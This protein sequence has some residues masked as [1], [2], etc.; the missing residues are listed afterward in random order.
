MTKTV[1]ENVAFALEVCG[2]PQDFINKRTT[3]VLKITGLED[4][5][6]YFPN[7]LS[8]GE[9]QRTAI[10]R[11]LVHTPDLIIA[12]EP[13]GNLDQENAIALA[14]L[15]VKINKSGTTVILS[16]HNQE[17]V[18]A[19]KTRVITIENGRIVSDKK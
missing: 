12:D 3:E 2:Y 17:I 11:A 13:T 10:A 19:L 16:T 4:K 7:Q 1:F 6:N 15:L 14:N 18:D 5:R 9:K 8:G